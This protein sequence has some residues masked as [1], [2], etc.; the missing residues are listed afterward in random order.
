MAQTIVA[1]PS[2]INSHRHLFYGISRKMLTIINKAT[3][4]AVRCKGEKEFKGN[5]PLV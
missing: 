5:C 4:I 2:T 1:A 3:A